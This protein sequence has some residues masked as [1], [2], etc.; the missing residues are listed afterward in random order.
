LD[1]S[2]PVSVANSSVVTLS[3]APEDGV[4]VEFASVQEMLTVVHKSLHVN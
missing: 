4:A 3:P 2:I 1:W